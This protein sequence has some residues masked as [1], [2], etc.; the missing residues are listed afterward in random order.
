MYST[1]LKWFNY[2]N[3]FNSVVIVHAQNVICR[4]AYLQV[5]CRSTNQNLRY[6]AVESNWMTMNYVAQNTVDTK[7]NRIEHY[8]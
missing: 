4:L 1:S 6:L 3:F 2:C 8:F 5:H 7:I